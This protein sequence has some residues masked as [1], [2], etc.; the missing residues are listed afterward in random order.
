MWKKQSLSIIALLS[1]LLFFIQTLSQGGFAGAVDTQNSD[2]TSLQVLETNVVKEDNL[3]NQQN[4]D[5]I[6]KRR[7]AAKKMQQEQINNL[8][9]E[10]QNKREQNSQNVDKNVPDYTVKVSDEENKERAA[11][12]EEFRSQK[13]KEAEKAYSQ[14]YEQYRD[15]K[16]RSAIFTYTMMNQN[17]NSYNKQR[18]HE[19]AKE[20]AKKQKKLQKQ[21]EY[22]NQHNAEVDARN[23]QRKYE[24]T[25][26]YK[27]T[28]NTTGNTNYT[29]NSGVLDK[30][31]KDYNYAT[32]QNIQVTPGYVPP[33]SDPVPV[34]K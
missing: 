1:F 4:L 27:N 5:E 9:N 26:Q 33:V 29:N 21:K 22:I 17:F 11:K 31:L 16:Q 8:V 28:T 32:H 6:R 18:A 30:M 2:K 24:Q 3:N 7:A 12:A 20:Q 25:Q 13:M 14:K 10:V 19:K 15:D 34:D 23:A